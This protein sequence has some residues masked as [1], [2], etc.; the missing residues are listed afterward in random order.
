[1]KIS[2]TFTIHVNPATVPDLVLIP[3][4]GALPDET[5]GSAATGG[6]TSSGGAPPVTFAV[7]A[8]SLPPGVILDPATGNLSG[9]PTSAGD[10]SFEITATDSN[11]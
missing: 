8:G 2:G 1:M 10:A 5:V 7:T 11:G 6:V 9:S 4:S 3:G